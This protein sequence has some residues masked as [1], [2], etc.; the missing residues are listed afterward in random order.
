MGEEVVVECGLWGG[1]VPGSMRVVG[2][3]LQK[4]WPSLGKGGGVSG[5]RYRGGSR[6]GSPSC[7]GA[8]AGAGLL[9][10]CL[11]DLSLCLPSNTCF[12]K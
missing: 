12:N 8:G 5:W 7:P 9:R 6:G 4:E 1:C 2:G 10:L 3:R 11:D